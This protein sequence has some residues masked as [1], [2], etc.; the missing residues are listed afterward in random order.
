MSSLKMYNSNPMPK[1]LTLPDGYSVVKWKNDEDI[2]AW[3]EICSDGLIDPATGYERF[4]SEITNADGPEALRDT[5]FIEKDGKK[6][7]TFTVV[8]NMWSTGMGNIHMVACKSECRGFGIGKFIADYSLKLLKEI[9]KENNFLLTH[10]NRIPAIK[11]YIG[12]GFLPVDYPTDD[13]TLMVDRWQKIINEIKIPEITI[14]D[15]DGNF[16]KIIKC[17]VL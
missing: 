6:V 16:E 7:A 5:Y 8:P 9:G 1:G 15:N 10:D 2:H 14:L 4:H 12:A 11:T 13:G 3:V 17:E